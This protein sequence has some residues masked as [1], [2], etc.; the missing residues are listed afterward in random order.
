MLG[1]PSQLA[2]N[3]KRAHHNE[4]ERKRRDHIKDSFSGLKDAIPTLQVAPGKVVFYEEIVLHQLFDQGDK[5]SRAQILKKASEYIAFMRRKNGSHTNDIED[6]R[7]Q[8]AHL[9]NQI[10]AMEKAKST[11]NFSSTGLTQHATP[12]FDRE[13]EEEDLENSAIKN[14]QSGQAS[15]ENPEEPQR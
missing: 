11:G 3:G 9:E 5:C 10:R 15:S 4:L 1:F 7:R 12:D 13:E 6:L 2:N 8:N 14:S